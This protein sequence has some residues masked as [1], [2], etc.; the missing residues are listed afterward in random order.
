MSTLRRSVFSTVGI[1]ICCFI[2]LSGMLPD[3]SRAGGTVVAFG[4]SITAGYPY[5]KNGNGCVNCGGYEPYLQYYLDWWDGSGRYVYNY[6]VGG[7]YLTFQGINRIDSVMAATYPAEYVL[8]MEGTNDLAFYFDPATIAYYLYAVAARVTLWGATPI[9]A[10]LTPD[11]R[12]GWDWK[13]ISTTNAYIKSY[14]NSNPLMCLSDQ[15]A[16]LAPYWSYGYSYDG[17]HPNYYGYWLM[18]VNWYY[19]IAACK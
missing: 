7:E 11:T 1:A 9:V 17:L 13:N 18:G 10:T 2:A 6:G 16:A 14:V 5:L 4:D 19:A 15:Y 8:I 12:Y 3:K